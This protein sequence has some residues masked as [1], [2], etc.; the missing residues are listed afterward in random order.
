MT[1]C[2]AVGARKY[3]G[4][5]FKHPRLQRAVSPSDLPVG[6]SVLVHNMLHIVICN[7][8][9]PLSYFISQN[10]GNFPS[11]RRVH[12][13]DIQL[14]QLFSILVLSPFFPSVKKA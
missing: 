10:G 3:I 8:E 13:P 7:D 9:V 11:N 4:K 12:L 6:I 2:D 1:R 5:R 14:F